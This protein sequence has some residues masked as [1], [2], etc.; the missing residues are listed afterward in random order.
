MVRLFLAKH[1]ENLE[2]VELILNNQKKIVLRWS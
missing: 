1:L 2:L